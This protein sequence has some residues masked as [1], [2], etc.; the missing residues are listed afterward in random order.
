MTVTVEL[1]DGYSLHRWFL[2]QATTYNSRSGTVELGYEQK[3]DRADEI[4]AWSIGRFSDEN[5]DLLFEVL[6]AYSEDNSPTPQELA[7]LIME[8]SEQEVGEYLVLD[9]YEEDEGDDL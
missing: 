8:I 2:E 6:D 7:R 5:W 4:G 1:N 9:G 3:H